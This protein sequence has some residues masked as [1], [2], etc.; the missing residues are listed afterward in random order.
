M[1]TFKKYQP[2]ETTLVDTVTCDLCGTKK[3][4]HSCWNAG[5]DFNIA[6]TRLE[7]EIG[8][9]CPDGGDKTETSYDICTN[10]FQTKLM[11][12]LESQGAKPT[13]T[14]VDW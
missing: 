8:W 3:P 5:D 9:G 1:K 2:P 13:V 12:W 4:G 7:M 10:C 6:A 14:N 11:P